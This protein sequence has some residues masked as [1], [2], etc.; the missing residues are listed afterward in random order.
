M[1]RPSTKLRYLMLR[2]MPQ[3]NNPKITSKAHHIFALETASLES[4]S[5]ELVTG[6]KPEERNWSRHA[7]ITV[8]KHEHS[9]ALALIPSLIFG[10]TP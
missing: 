4:C 1:E 7:T 6:I 10:S 9:A 2:F 5:P 8:P 3:L